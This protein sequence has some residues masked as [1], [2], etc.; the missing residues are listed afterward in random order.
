[1]ETI[2]IILAVLWLV[3]AFA[4][5]NNGQTYIGGGPGVSWGGVVILVL[6]FLFFTHRF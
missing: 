6:A 3:G 5:I 2:L 4:P 1:M